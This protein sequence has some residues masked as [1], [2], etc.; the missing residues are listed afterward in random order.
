MRLILFTFVFLFLIFNNAFSQGGNVALKKSATSAT[1][2]V[3]IGSLTDDN[4]GS[5]CFTSPSVSVPIYI[6]IDLGDLY[7]LT[8]MSVFW[9]NTTGWASN[10]QM[11]TS[12][13][14]NYWSNF[15]TAITNKTSN[16]PFS[17]A[18]V[19]TASANARY[20]RIYIISFN[21]YGNGYP[22]SIGEIQVFSND[23]FVNN[24]AVPKNFTVAGTSTF[25]GASSF[26][27]NI[28]VAGTSTFSGIVNTNSTVNGWAS[29]IQNQGCIVYSAYGNS[30]SDGYGMHIKVNNTRSD[31]YAL[32]CYDGT[33]TLFKVGND[34][35]SSFSNNVSIG[36][37]LTV[38]GD[39]NFAGGGWIRAT[40]GSIHLP[41]Y[42]GIGGVDCPTNDTKLAVKGNTI[43][44][45]KL[46]VESIKVQVPAWADYVF[47]PNYKLPS[48]TE[49]EAYIKA[50]G[51]LQ[52][53]PSATEV[54]ENGFDVGEMNKILLQKVEEMTL[55]MIE[56]NK[57][58]QS[59]NERIKALEKANTGK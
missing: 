17:P 21:G 52:G 12:T 40:D 36:K 19:F 51:H 29:T 37:N 16:P 33:N 4:I 43:I 27:N 7:S 22:F 50:N 23:A 20:V 46:Y 47:T 44:Y 38:N 39:V 32:M 42:V 53:V 48:F 26:G 28:S 14:G 2:F 18:D 1:Q 58:V 41:N 13:T 54:K 31:R 11:Q 3:S 6:T 9:A 34:G 15:G 55:L 30:S 25:I 5:S 59:Q 57:I 56:Q 24:V 35:N 8:S 10:Y 45:G 49:T